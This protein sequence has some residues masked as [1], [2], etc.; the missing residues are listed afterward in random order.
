LSKGQFI[1]IDLPFAGSS[2]TQANEFNAKGT[3]LDAD[4]V[5]HGFLAEGPKFTSVDYPGA[6]EVPQRGALIQPGRWSGIGS[7]AMAMS[8]VG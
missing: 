6:R 3:L 4:G 7:T 1:T 2:D 5:P 8:T